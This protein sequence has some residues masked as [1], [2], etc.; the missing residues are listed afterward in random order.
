MRLAADLFRACALG[1]HTFEVRATDF[2]GQHRPHAGPSHWTVREKT[3]ADLDPPTQG[4]DVNVDQVSRH[5]ARGTDGR[6]GARGA[7]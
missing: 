5:R 4:V 2:T 6:G 7:E 1:A 3:L